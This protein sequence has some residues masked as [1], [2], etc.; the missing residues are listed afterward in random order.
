M[1][2][3]LCIGILIVL[4]AW[5][6]ISPLIL[7]VDTRRNEYALRW[8]G[9]VKASFIPMPADILLRL[10]L[11]FWRRDFSLL[12]LLAT[13]QKNKRRTV[14]KASSGTRKTGR[15]T[16][17]RFRRLIKSFRVEYFRLELDTDDYVTNA[18]LYPLCYALRIPKGFVAINFQGRNQCAFQ[19]KNRLVNLLVAFIF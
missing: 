11:P 12:K 5:L 1:G 13:P 9:L 7:Q 3:L 15:F 2:V 14:K 6:L 16:W 4:L 8:V 19:I 10:Q 18:Y 17:R